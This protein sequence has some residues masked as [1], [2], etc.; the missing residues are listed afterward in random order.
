MFRYDLGYLPQNSYDL[1]YLARSV[2]MSGSK[3]P[4]R[5]GLF[6]S[7]PTYSVPYFTFDVISRTV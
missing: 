4:A 3:V 2:R 5:A 1:K 7:C 6:R